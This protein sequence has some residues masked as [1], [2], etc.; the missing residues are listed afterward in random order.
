MVEADR[1]KR[2]YEKTLRQLER[3]I[4]I[5]GFRKGK[6]P[7]NL[8]VRQVGRERV[9]ASAIDDLIQEA[10]QEVLQEAQVTPSASLSWMKR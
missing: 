5:P 9:I 7:R 10:I 6:A 8:V 1:V 3:N 2:S 4:Q